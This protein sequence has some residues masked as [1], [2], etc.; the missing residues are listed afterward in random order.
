MTWRT[1][2]FAAIN[3]KG[4]LEYFKTFYGVCHNFLEFISSYL[5]FS[6]IFKLVNFSFLV[7][8]TI[9]EQRAP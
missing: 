2:L 3:F 9:Y 4:F 5:M 1:T 6:I 8:D 7:T